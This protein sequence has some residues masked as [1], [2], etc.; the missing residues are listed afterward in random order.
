[1]YLKPLLELNIYVV[2]FSPPKVGRWRASRIAWKTGGGERSLQDL[3]AFFFM[4][5]MCYFDVCYFCHVSYYQGLLIKDVTTDLTFSIP[6]PPPW[7]HIVTI[8]WPCPPVK[9]TSQ[10]STSITPVRF[11]KFKIR[12][13]Q[14]YIYFINTKCIYCMHAFNYK[15]WNKYFFH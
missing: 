6:C 3:F 11:K 10:I 4:L 15:R 9:V 1:M 8:M 12:S 2:A 14:V 5:S 7:S 13:V